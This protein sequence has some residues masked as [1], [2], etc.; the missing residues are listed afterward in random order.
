MA[1]EQGRSPGLGGVCG[2]EAPSL[3]LLWH[4]FGLSQHHS[5]WRK[6]LVLSAQGSGVGPALLCR[7]AADIL[8]GFPAG[9]KPDRNDLSLES[10][11]NTRF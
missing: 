10:N 2:W 8:L 4:W 3:G 9:K 5:D 1:S 7:L 11:L 6:L